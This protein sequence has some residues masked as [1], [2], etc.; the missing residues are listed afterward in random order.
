MITPSEHSVANLS[1]QTPVCKQGV[2]KLVHPARNPD[3]VS[4]LV[5]EPRG[6]EWM[7]FRKFMVSLAHNTPPVKVMQQI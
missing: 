4:L 5:R 2:E 7:V 1:P 3:E 6:R